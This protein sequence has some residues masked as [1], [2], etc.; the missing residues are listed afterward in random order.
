MYL[1]IHTAAGILIGKLAPNPIV[2]FIA[3]LTSHFLLDIFP[4]GDRGWGKKVHETKDARLFLIILAVDT[5]ITFFM[6]SRVIYIVDVFSLNYWTVGAGIFGAVLP[7]MLVG[8]HELGQIIFKGKW[9]FWPKFANFHHSIHNDIV[10]KFDLSFFPGL[11]LQ[12]VVLAIIL[13][14]I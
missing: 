6:L 8:I 4:H 14:F 13:Q 5:A 11:A 12:A 9:K 10:K 3:G 7:D 1:T 2:A